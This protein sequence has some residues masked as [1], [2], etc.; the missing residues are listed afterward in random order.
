MKS[1]IAILTTLLTFAFS[2]ISYACSCSQAGGWVSK[3]AESKTVAWARPVQSTWLSDQSG[4]LS[5]GNVETQFEVLDGFSRI[6]ETTITVRHRNDGAACGIYPTLGRLDLIIAY[7][8]RN[9]QEYLATNSCT[10]NSIDPITLIKYLETGEDTY[11]PSFWKCEQQKD[12]GISLEDNCEYLS[13]EAE[14]QRRD[15]YFAF[16]KK[17]RLELPTEP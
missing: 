4:R 15:E 14:K 10:M 1:N 6:S 8:S 17:K 9:S 3:V 5:S 12:E 2:S 11:V 16:M 13:E 7:D